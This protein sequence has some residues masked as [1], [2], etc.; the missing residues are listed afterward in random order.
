[1]IPRRCGPIPGAT[2]VDEQLLA[3]IGISDHALER[4]AQRAGQPHGSRRQLE[5][6]VR[7]LLLQEG[8]RVPGPPGWAHVRR[9]P[10]YLQAGDWLLF[11]ARPNA[12]S[13]ARC[14]TITTVIAREDLAWAPAL[15]RGWIATP[16]PC[17]R[18]PPRPA[19][20]TV[21]SSALEL[22][23]RGDLR[24]LLELPSSHRRRRHEAALAFDAAV[25][26]WERGQLVHKAARERAH[27]A[28]LTRNGFV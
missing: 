16:P 17:H 27:S 7:D 6:V 1:V 25:A 9:A 10:F 12:R 5:A 24:L 11:T 3:A 21:R 2:L 22:L 13:A 4:F 8:L 26:E 15:E 14:R 20:V 28:H 23:G 18:A 19:S